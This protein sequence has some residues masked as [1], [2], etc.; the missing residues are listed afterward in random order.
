MSAINTL[1]VVFVVAPIVGGLIGAVF[2]WI[3]E[4]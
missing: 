1:L 2:Y 3:T 4:G